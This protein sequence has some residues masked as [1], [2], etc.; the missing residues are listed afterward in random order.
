MKTEEYSALV[1]CCVIAA[2]NLEHN[3]IKSYAAGTGI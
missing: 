3:W 2:R 1:C